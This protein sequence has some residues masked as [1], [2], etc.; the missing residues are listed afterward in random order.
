MRLTIIP[1]VIPTEQQYVDLY[2][3]WPDLSQVQLEKQ[4]ATGQQFYAARF[5]ERLLGAAKITINSSSATVHDFCIREVTRRRGVG[6]YLLEKICQ[7]IPDITQ[8]KFDMSGVVQQEKEAVKLF[9]AA[10][11][12]NS[13]TQPDIWEKWNEIK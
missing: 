5:N 8:W 12:F 2:K 1:L 7:G 10:Q 13:S 11:G 6:S 9:L 3:I 4:L